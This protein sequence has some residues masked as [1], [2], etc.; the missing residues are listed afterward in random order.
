M[1]RNSS[2][3]N[4]AQS[5]GPSNLKLDDEKLKYAVLAQQNGF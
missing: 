3:S 4:V 5:M 2:S 1:Y